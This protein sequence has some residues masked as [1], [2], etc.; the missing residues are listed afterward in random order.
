[1]LYAFAKAL[2]KII[3]IVLGRYKITGQENIP[4]KGPVIVVCNH[5][6]YWDPIVLG[7]AL[8]RQ[9]YFMAKAELFSIPIFGNILKR[10]GAFPIKRGHSDHKALRTAIRLLKEGKVLGV[11]PEGTRSKKGSLLPFRTGITMIAYKAGCP[12]V[13]VGLINSKKVLI[14]WWKPVEV[15]IGKPMLFPQVIKRPSSEELEEW[16]E[17]SRQAVAFLL[18]A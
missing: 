3:L 15:K 12:I 14:G 17:Q 16:T 9:V 10:L 13:P 11:F 4:D 7:C 8:N 6:S 2:F 5:V 1:M 18:G